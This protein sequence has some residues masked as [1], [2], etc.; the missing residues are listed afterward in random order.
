MMSSLHS[1]CWSELLLYE[2]EPTMEVIHWSY[3]A[4]PETDMLRIMY[5]LKLRQFI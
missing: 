1:C 2:L 4:R 5:D 3:K